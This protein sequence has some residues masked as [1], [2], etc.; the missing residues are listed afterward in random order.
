MRSPTARQA[1][2]LPEIDGPTDGRVVSVTDHNFKPLLTHAGHP[3]SWQ[4]THMVGGMGRVYLRVP[5][6]AEGEST[7]LIGVLL[8]DYVE[9]EQLLRSG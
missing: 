1:A 3:H 4:T 6:L 8:G 2:T 5:P 7:Q 9:L